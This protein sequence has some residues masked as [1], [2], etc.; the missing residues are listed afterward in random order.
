[1]IE[2]RIEKEVWAIL[3][4]VC[5]AI[6]AGFVGGSTG[7][8]CE[9]HCFVPDSLNDTMY[10]VVNHDGERTL[11]EIL[12]ANNYS[13]NVSRDQTNIQVW[14]TTGEVTIG[15]EFIDKVAAYHHAFGYYL[16]RDPLTFVP[17]FETSNHPNFTKP[18]VSPGDRFVFNVP[19]GNDVGFMIDTY[20]IWNGKRSQHFT[21]NELNDDLLDHAIVFDLCDEFVL[22]FENSFGDFD[23]QDIVVSINRE[24]CRKIPICGNGILERGEECDDG[25]LVSGDG[26]N[27]SCDIECEDEDGDGVCDK[28]DKCEDSLEGELVDEDGCDPFQY[29]GRFSCGFDC[30][31]ADWRNNEAV[32]F[33]N[34]CVVVMRYLGG[35]PAQPICVPTEFSKKCSS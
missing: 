29:C 6:C 7:P 1:M 35:E 8:V 10:D 26:C 25:N 13:I 30:Y 23:Y 31:Y 11:Q 27:S 21:E 32:L 9:Y 22:A 19:I 17:L 5:I 24:S 16:N 12:D 18:V 3:F 4:V 34:D 20:N 33:P 15:L 14:H 28:D 2:R